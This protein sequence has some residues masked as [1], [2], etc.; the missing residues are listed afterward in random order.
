MRESLKT[1]L[2]AF[3]VGGLLA[4]PAGAEP[5]AAETA[6]PPAPEQASPLAEPAG[7]A[8]AE[9]PVAASENPT[10]AAGAEPKPAGT[11]V[12]AAP[13]ETARA[14][15]PNADPDPLDMYDNDQPPAGAAKASPPASG[16]SANPA[17]PPAAA[18]APPPP[19]HDP[20]I[21][22]VREKL[23]SASG[24]GQTADA[25]AALK[26]FYVAFAGAPLWVSAD[27]FTA[28]GDAVIEEIRKAADWGLAAQA[29]D[30]PA[31]PAGGA[32]P[33]ILAD[34]EIEAGLAAL[35]Y[36]NHARG[37]RIDPPS[38]S[39]MFDRKPELPDPKPLMGELAASEDPAG[40]LRSQH[41]Q[42][43]QFELLRQALLAARN[44]GA[45][46]PE[47]AQ[48]EIPGGP[49][50]KPGSDHPHIALLRQRLK[51]ASETGKEANY[52]DALASAVKAFQKENGLKASGFLN[53]ATRN[54]LNGVK[55]PT[56]AGEIQRILV[57]MER[58][59]WMPRDLGDFYVWDNVPE[60]MTY[61]VKK[62][63]VIHSAKIVVGKP[64]NPTPSFTAN[65]L[66]VIFHPDW[67]VPNGIKV[68]ELWPYLRGT[69]Y[70]FFGFGGGA[71]TR[72]LQQQ[73]L[74]VS[75][76]GRPIDP[77]QV[78]WNNVDIRRY[79]F[80][81][82]PGPTNVL[83]VVKFRFP[84]RHDV[85]MHDTPQ[86]NLFETPNRAFSH[87]CMRVQ[88]PIKL[89][90]ILL[91]EDQGLSASD[92]A[93]LASHSNQVDL[94]TPVPVHVAYFTAVAGEGGTVKTFGDVYGHD[95][96]LASALEGRSV[97]VANDGNPDNSDFLEADPSSQRQARAQRRKPKQ[98]E[99]INDILSGIFGN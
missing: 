58:W 87:G 5:I 67:G 9:T 66:Y 28:R 72:I 57:N 26:E 36:A 79:S 68:E 43:R 82:P 35:K 75:Y 73:N 12:E 92:V 30:L 89:A 8:N 47:E 77:S 69:D 83:G 55:K 40:L 86:R 42:H 45:S 37:G 34:A 21:A 80:T 56:K 53:N 24:K 25:R 95:S 38:V 84:N 70:G 65:M 71:D 74:R 6:K 20:V 16:D 49:T 91:A 1:A 39:S 52:D 4:L 32:A 99:P 19:P 14:A 90:E 63:E 10:G 18:E 22:A 11:P 85:Y 81:Q 2:A 23:E 54:A 94:K 61:V 3:V 15:S 46:K 88:N 93:R 60:F 48:V 29:F 76:N 41:P 50:L 96:R 13:G 97:A 62:N 33:E 59:R 31:E 17:E 27:G 51:A 44:P 78:N 98:V 64:K 7:G